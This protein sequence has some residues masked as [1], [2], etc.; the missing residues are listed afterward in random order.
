MSVK[1]KKNVSGCKTP[2]RKEIE[3][4]RV[5]LSCKTSTGKGCQ[6]WNT[7]FIRPKYKHTLVSG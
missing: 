1:H 7:I 6:T 2:K 4:C 5:E 3:Q